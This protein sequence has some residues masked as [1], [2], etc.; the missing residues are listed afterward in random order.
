MESNVSEL[1]T[2]FLVRHGHAGVAGPKRYIGQSDLPLSDTGILQAQ[3]LRCWFAS[4]PLARIIASDLKRAV[5]T[6]RIIAESHHIEIECLPEF[7]EIH[8]GEWDGRTFDEIK[9][10]HPD[11]FQARGQDLAGF[12]PSGGESFSDLQRR[13][14]PA[15]ERCLRKSPGDLLLVAHAGVNR[16]VLCH[17]L[18]IPL[19][20]LFRIG[21]D[22]GAVTVIQLREDRPCVRRLNL[23]PTP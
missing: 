20:H 1:R 3:S 15:L 12:R 18:E 4:I 22:C 8:L 23:L 2:L 14:I 21:Q 10:N 9:N 11:A 7:R 13:V 17:F 16:V 6:A 19:T 5:G